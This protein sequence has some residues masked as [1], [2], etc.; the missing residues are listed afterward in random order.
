MLV[1]NN[2]HAVR[3]LT[4]SSPPLG[5]RRTREV[6]PAAR[7]ADA[8]LSAAAELLTAEPLK[9]DPLFAAPVAPVAPACA[10]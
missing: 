3:E 5:P 1:L 9:A 10:S 8:M 7:G 6:V 2:P 4:L